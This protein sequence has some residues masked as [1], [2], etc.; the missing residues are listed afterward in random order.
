MLSAVAKDLITDI[1]VNG[2]SGRA[3]VERLLQKKLIKMTPDIDYEQWEKSVYNARYRGKQLVARNDR[4]RPERSD[5]ASIR[6]FLETHS[7]FSEC[8]SEVFCL[9]YR[10]DLPDTSVEDDVF[11][12][13]DDVEPNSEAV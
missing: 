10:C 11:Q 8:G 9:S 1:A 5:I 13:R 4:P 3:T 12:A 6:A 7:I 2:D